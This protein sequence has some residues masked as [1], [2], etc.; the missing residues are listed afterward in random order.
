[1][2]EQNLLKMFEGILSS[3]AFELLS[4]FTNETV[5]SSLKAEEREALAQL[6]LLHGEKCIRSSI[7]KD[8]P[9][10]KSAFLSACRLTPK[11]AKTWFR[12]GSYLALGHEDDELI[13]A[14]DALARSIELDDRFFDA[15]YAL[16]SAQLRLGAH[17]SDESFL[18]QADRSFQKAYAL[19]EST[20]PRALPAS[21]YWHW[22]IVCF[23]L[24]R[25]SQE[26]SDFQ[27]ALLHYQEAYT[28]G[29]RVPEFLHDFANACVEF[30]LLLGRYEYVDRAAK[31][32]EESL[33]SSEQDHQTSKDKAIRLFNLACCYVHLFEHSFDPEYY[34][35]AE[36]AFLQAYAYE[37][38]ETIWQK[39]GQ[40]YFT[41]ARATLQREQVEKSIESFQKA[42]ALGIEHPLMLALYSQALLLLYDIRQDSALLQDA[43]ELAQLSLSQQEA[44]GFVSAEPKLALALCLFEIGKYF[45]D[46]SYIEKA[47]EEVQKALGSYPQSVYLWHA[48]GRIKC[49]IAEEDRQ[50]EI[51][52]EAIV[53]FLLASR[54]VLGKCSSFWNEW[55]ILLLSLADLTSD[56]IL[57]E[58]ACAK[59]EIAIELSSFSEVDWMYNLACGLDLLG[60]LKD[61]EELHERAIDLFRYVEQEDPTIYTVLLQQATAHIH[62]GEM[63]NTSVHFEQAESLLVRY[64]VEEPEEEYAWA[65]LGIVLL[66]LAAL[67][68]RAGD[69]EAF[70]SYLDRA[71]STLGNAISLGHNQGYYYLACLHTLRMNFS[72]AMECL[73]KAEEER[74]LPSLQDVV[75]EEWLQPLISTQAFGQFFAEAI[76]VRMEVATEEEV[77]EQQDESF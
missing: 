54:S 25:I 4:E 29:L 31:L 3:Q 69:E 27:R 42:Y 51:L 15:H 71:E 45:E 44:T 70:Y 40:L 6:F 62:L 43:F 22:G 32:Y 56:P 53:C 39:L 66:H 11:S 18:L 30:S 34:Q 60:S 17:K 19:L 16:A 41:A 24:G 76:D 61:D 58:D 55:G 57:A 67:K 64:L 49:P 5:W 73:W 63:Q 8:R 20:M 1:M 77:D 46:I 72:E 13:E 7:E 21:F 28:L 38:L 36:S 37:P 14:V 9:L 2:S 47:Q 75:D 68:K 12:Y 74:A 59:F 65:E 52:K 35:K 23:L 33:A 48:L 50:E 10:A 26:P